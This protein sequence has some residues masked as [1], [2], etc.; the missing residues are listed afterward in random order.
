MSGTAPGGAK[1]HPSR[2][3]RGTARPDAPA[4]PGLPARLA[5]QRLLTAIVDSHTSLD[6]LTDDQH[7]HPQRLWDRETGVIVT[8]V[9]HS[10]EAYDIRL[11]LERNCE[12]L[13]PQL[14]GKIHIFMGSE[15]TFLLE[16]ATRKLKES[17]AS[18]GSDAIVEIHEGKDHGSLMTPQLRDR[19]RL[20]MTSEFLTHFPQWPD[21]GGIIPHTQSDQR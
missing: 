10:W 21:S 16:G 7:G 18:L 9:G 12:T 13:G 5:A 3:N 11:I 15:D 8:D 17:L 4:K 2:N 19:I 1:R 6:G 14:A 20:E